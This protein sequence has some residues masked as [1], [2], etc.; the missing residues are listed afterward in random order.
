M[1]NQITHTLTQSEYLSIL[2]SLTHY[3]NTHEGKRRKLRDETMIATLW[4]TGLR[5]GELVMLLTSDLVWQGEPVQVLTVREAIAKKGH[6]RRIP[7]STLLRSHII[8]LSRIWLPADSFSTDQFAFQW[9]TAWQHMSARHVQRIIATAAA[10]SLNRNIHPH[11]LRHSFGTR[12]MRVTNARVVQQLLGHRHLSSTQ[13]Y[14][15]P[16]HN[17]LR[18]AIDAAE[19]EEI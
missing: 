4:H 7:V 3:P 9:R 19:V 11:M 10:K 17:D 1:T 16:D 2:A 8:R 13:I 14:T 6:E 12:M 18:A 15:H 5:V